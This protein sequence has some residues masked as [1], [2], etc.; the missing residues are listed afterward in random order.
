MTPGPELQALLVV[1]ASIV[2]V[3]ALMLAAVALGGLRRARR[4]VRVLARDDGLAQLQRYL[5]AQDQMRVQLE[6]LEEQSF[7]LRGLAR[8]ALSGTGLVRY[9]AFDGVGGLLSFSTALVDERGDGVVVTAI[10]GR[11][12]SRVFAKPVMRG[13]SSHDLSGEEREAITLARARAGR[14]PNPSGPAAPARASA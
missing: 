1:A 5:R 7:L 10:N 6:R 8:N 9:D 4:A 2:A 3:V 11:A 14:R 13:E 12:E